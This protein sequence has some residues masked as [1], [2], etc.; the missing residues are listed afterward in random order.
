MIRFFS[1]III[2]LFCS[3]NCIGGDITDPLDYESDNTLKGYIKEI[4]D[5]VNTGV[6]HAEEFKI[7]LSDIKS[8]QVKL[9]DRSLENYYEIKIVKL[10]QGVIKKQVTLLEEQ[11]KET[12]KILDLLSQGVAKSLRFV[13]GAYGLGG[14]ILGIICT[15]IGGIITKYII[16]KR[17]KH[18]L[19]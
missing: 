16:K 1:A 19:S 8:D 10:E 2:L 5:G 14:V 18:A 17:K 3:I 15:V 4:R 7:D 9:S 11:G 12:R 13:N 6:R